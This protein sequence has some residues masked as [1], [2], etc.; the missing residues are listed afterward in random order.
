M[1]QN[2]HYSIHQYW[3]VN[4]NIFQDFHSLSLSLF[5]H[6]ISYPSKFTPINQAQSCS[7][8]I[9]PLETHSP[10]VLFRR[11]LF[12]SRISETVW[13][14][15]R[16]HDAGQTA[17]HVYTRWG[18][19]CLNFPGIFVSWVRSFCVCV[20]KSLV[21]G[22]GCCCEQYPK[23]VVVRMHFIRI[24]H[25]FIWPNYSVFSICTKHRFWVNRWK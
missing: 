20:E 19:L 15:L 12:Y 25:K 8:Q 24:N 7:R 10:A 2:S 14:R 5:A 22:D 1:I 17:F 13:W 16:S 3:T 9:T 11:S 4:Q 18:A 21:M 23:V 6:I